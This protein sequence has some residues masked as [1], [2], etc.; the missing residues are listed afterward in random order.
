MLAGGPVASLHKATVPIDPAV[1]LPDIS[2]AEPSGPNL[3]F[4]LD[5]GEFERL[6]QGKPEQQYGTTIV[7]AEEPDWKAVVAA[8]WALLDRTYD[9]RICAQMAVARLQREGLAGY[10]DALAM[11][12]QLLEARWS[13]VHPLLDPEDDTDPTLRAN[14]VLSVAAPIEAFTQ[15]ADGSSVP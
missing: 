9:L 11:I 3:E 2:D 6:T 7:A 14:A 13:Q 8:G 4:D 10:A 5:F 1:P 15:S 12:R